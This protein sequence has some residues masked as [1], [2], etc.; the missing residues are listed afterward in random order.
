MILLDNLTADAIA[1]LSFDDLIA[2]H[3]R[4]VDL[5]SRILRSID[6]RMIANYRTLPNVTARPDCLISMRDLAERMNRSRE[7]IYRHAL[8]LPFLHRQGNRWEASERE[9][10]RWVTSGLNGHRKERIKKAA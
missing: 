1:S 3:D 7:W 4:L 5:H 2:A 9:F 8:E 10:E 6:A